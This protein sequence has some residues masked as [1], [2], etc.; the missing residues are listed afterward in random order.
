[1]WTVVLGAGLVLLW[2]SGFVG[3]TMGTA[4]ATAITLL[5]W[6][7]LVAGGV[8]LAWRRARITP[9]QVVLG[10]LS[11]GG[12][13]M[14]VYE[15]AQLGVAA[16]TSALIAALQPVVTVVLGQR[17]L[18]ER[19]G[20][21]QWMGLLIGLGGVALVVGDD[22][23]GSTAPLWA[24]ALPFGSMLALVAATI[25][26]RRV[27]PATSVG[28]SLVVQCGTSAVL[29][30]GLAAATGQLVPPMTGSFW[31]SVGWIVVLSTFGAY[32][33]YWALLRRTSATTVSSLLY[34]TP[35]TT[36]VLAWLMFGQGLTGRGLL[37]LAICLAG[38][39]LVLL[40]RKLS[41]LRGR[42]SPCC[43]PTSSPLP[44]HSPPR[45]RGR[46]KSRLWRS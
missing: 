41:V 18:G 5:T 6:R 19:A 11:Q 32:G 26:E 25:I 36:M 3:A 22:L 40:P 2:S 35:P 39:V 24:Y 44:R 13:L 30:A 38:V 4:S 43:S 12:Y 28:D 31:F 20:P 7:F 17:L 21:R 33:C 14:G 27:S 37:G 23:T 45:D 42:M 15:A 34:L 29:F 1:M 16:G 9:L 10:L 46:R 8:L